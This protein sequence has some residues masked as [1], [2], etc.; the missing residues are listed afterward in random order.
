MV[1]RAAGMDL[2]AGSWAREYLEYVERYAIPMPS[3]ENRETDT[4]TPV[5][6]D[7]LIPGVDTHFN[8]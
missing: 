7:A 6:S 4:D 1:L 2:L 3:V 8:A 5:I